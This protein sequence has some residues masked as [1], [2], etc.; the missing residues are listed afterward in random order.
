[1]TPSNAKNP[2]L[3]QTL[4]ADLLRIHGSVFIGGKEL[5]EAL[6]YKTDI[7]FRVAMSKRRL[8]V[9]LFK[10][11]GRKGHW[12]LIRDISAWL[13]SVSSTVD[14]YCADANHQAIETAKPKKEV[15]LKA[16]VSK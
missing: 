12:A 2:S 10:I 9:P 3:A 11:P 6:R 15:K 8:G 16:P 14:Q 1:M 5:R 7:A 4:E 13:A